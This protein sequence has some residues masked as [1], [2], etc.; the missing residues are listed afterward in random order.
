MAN[1]LE[2]IVKQ[3][4][5]TVLTLICMLGTLAQAADKPFLMPVEDSFY[6]N[7][8]GTVI[9][10]R[11]ERGNVAVGQKIDLVGLG[12]TQ[13]ATVGSIEMARKML[14]E[15]KTGDNVGLI[16]KGID[17]TLVKR[18]QV[19]VKVGSVTPHQKFVAKIQFL[20]S[21][22]GGRKMPVTVGYRSQ[23]FVRTTDV[24]ATVHLPDAKK[25]VLPGEKSEATLELTEVIA[26]EKGQS[27]AL[28][29]SGRIIGTGT[30]E[31]IL[32]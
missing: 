9:T 32:D 28:R 26:L 16:L 3:S 1:G 30:V 6:I 12:A 31:R 11:I 10:G 27:F 17:K 23:F 19:A 14:T 22:E 8:M 21:A 20:N 4:F 13:T 2:R 24:S 7:G 29:E 18:G 15:A 25:S 5:F